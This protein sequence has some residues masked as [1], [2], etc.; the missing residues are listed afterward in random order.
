MSRG[1]SWSW[2]M[3]TE[4][5]LGPGLHREFYITLKVKEFQSQKANSPY[6]IMTDIRDTVYLSRSVQRNLSLLSV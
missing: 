6:G 1:S 4:P 2:W 5:E 3:S